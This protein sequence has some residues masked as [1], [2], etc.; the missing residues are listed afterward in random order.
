MPPEKEKKNNNQEE[1]EVN[2]QETGTAAETEAQEPEEKAAETVREPS[3]E[4]KLRAENAELSDRLLRTMAEFDNFRKRSAKERD[5]IY[6]DAVANTVGKLLVVADSL[7]RALEAP[8][9]DEEYKKG[10]EKIY[11]SF[12]EGIGK[13]G[14]KEIP[15]KGEKFD[16]ELHNAVMHVE[17][18]TLGEGEI[19]EVFQKGYIMGDKVVR[20]SMVKVAN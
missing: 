14:V 7:E 9:S 1:P 2:G 16:P 11:A 5:A 10:V 17:D 20:H 19:I 15:A 13:L 6:P 18:E 12:I 8:C 4:E 3:E